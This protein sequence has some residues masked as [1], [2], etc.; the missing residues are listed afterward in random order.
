MFVGTPLGGGSGGSIIPTPMPMQSQ[1]P[2]QQRRWHQQVNANRTGPFGGFGPAVKVSQGRVG[3]D[4]DWVGPAPDAA[5]S[6][7]SQLDY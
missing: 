4:S 1:L 5:E 3:S 7:C 6:A 2:L